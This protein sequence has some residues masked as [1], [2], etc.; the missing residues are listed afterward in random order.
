MSEQQAQAAQN[1]QTPAFNLQRVYLKD[2]SV[3]MPNAPQTF[4]EQEAPTVSINV[5]VGGQRLADTVFEVTITVTVTTKIE[6]K[7]VY[8]VEATQG[9]IFELANMPAEQIDPILGIVCPTMLYP[10]LRSNVADAITRTSLPPLHLA[11][12]NFQ[13]LYEQRL[14]EQG[15]PAAVAPNGQS[16][17]SG[18]ILPPSMTRQ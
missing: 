5:G 18:L 1:E 15:Q 13:G 2:L 17:D 6:E 10:Y 14:A 7:V 11:D 8:L 4:L 12:I 3:E 16:N 9:G